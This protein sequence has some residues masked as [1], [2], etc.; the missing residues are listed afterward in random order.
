MQHHYQKQS[1]PQHSQAVLQNI[2]LYAELTAGKVLAK[3]LLIWFSFG[4]KL[5]SFVEKVTILMYDTVLRYD[6][7]KLLKQSCI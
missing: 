6:S 3:F 2:E 5:I 7:G 1:Q 4:F